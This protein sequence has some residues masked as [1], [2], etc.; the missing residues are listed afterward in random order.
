MGNVGRYGRERYGE[1]DGVKQ[2]TEN[3]ENIEHMLF[4]VTMN[5][6]TA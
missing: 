1:R 4:V 5:N 3:I 6:I 2:N